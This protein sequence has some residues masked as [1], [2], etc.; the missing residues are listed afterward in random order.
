M[1]VLLCGDGLSPGDWELVRGLLADAAP[2][3]S[4]LTSLDGADVTAVDVAVVAPP[5]PATLQ[6]LCVL[7]NL[8]LI[9]SLWAGVDRLLAEPGLPPQVPLLR[10]VDPAMNRAMAETALWAT[11]S[12][13]R[14]YFDYARQQAE[15]RWLPGPQRRADEVRV[16]VLGLGQMGATTAQVLRQ[17]GYRVAGWRLGAAAPQEAALHGIAV[18]IGNAALTPLLAASDIIINLLP[19]TER[20]RGL[21]DR[22]AFAALPRG[23]ALVNLARGAHV[24]DDDLLAALDAGQLSHAVLDVFHTEPLPVGHAYWSH[25]RVTVLPHVAAL[26]DPRS[27]TGIVAANIAAWRAGRPLAHGVDR[28]R[29]Y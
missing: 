16:A 28:V 9:H 11:L 4:W 12:L 18:H 25:P 19:L 15:R 22:R 7:P 20:T 10:M 2:E 23:A 14:G 13:H 3:E 1:S 21:L 6:G 5:L 17:H 27:A 24:V 26:T 29:G 8:R